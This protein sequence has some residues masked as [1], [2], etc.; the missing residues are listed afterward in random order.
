MVDAHPRD[1]MRNFSL[2]I[3]NDDELHSGHH[4]VDRRQWNGGVQLWKAILKSVSKVS[5]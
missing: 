1:Q 3:L 2:P 5:A 4:S